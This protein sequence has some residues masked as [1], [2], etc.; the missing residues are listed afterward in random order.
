MATSEP[1][2]TDR[3]SGWLCRKGC[4]QHAHA[5]TPQTLTA[6]E[7]A[8]GNKC[9]NRAEGTQGSPPN[10]DPGWEEAEKTSHP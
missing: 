6:R 1:L 9:F 2:G 7:L 10:L 4:E 5:L 3:V 8:R